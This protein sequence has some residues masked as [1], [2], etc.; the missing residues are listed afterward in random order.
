MRPSTLLPNFGKFAEL[1]TIAACLLFPAATFAK[2]PGHNVSLRWKEVPNARAY[3]VEVNGE[4]FWVMRNVELPGVELDLKPGKYRFRLATVD[5][6]GVQGEWSPWRDLVVQKTGMEIQSV[7]GTDLLVPGLRDFRRGH[8]YRATLTAGSVLLG[9]LVAADSSRKA[10]QTAVAARK[11]TFYKLYNE[12]GW[13]VAASSTA[14]FDSLGL[15]FLS[16]GFQDY[17]RRRKAYDSYVH[18]SLIGGVIFMLGCLWH[19]SQG[20]GWVGSEGERSVSAFQIS[21][22]GERGPGENYQESGVRF[23]LSFRL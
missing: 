23:L 14:Q 10:H 7:Q 12:P 8:P 21:L 3:T 15:L 1:C 13:I 9:G 5:A 4:D 20:M 18:R 6:Q 17:E 22:I 2:E 11:E 16:A 19:I